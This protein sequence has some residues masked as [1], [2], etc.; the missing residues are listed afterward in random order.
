MKKLFLNMLLILALLIPTL[1]IATTL[2][3]TQEDTVE[4]VTS[5][6]FLTLA[7]EYAKFTFLAMLIL[8]ANHIVAGTFNF[9]L[10]LQDSLIPA[11]LAYGGGLAVAALDIYATSWDFFVEAVLGAP[12]DY[13]D[14][15]NLA[16]TGMIL[17]AFIK[18]LF[19]INQTQEKVALKKAN[20]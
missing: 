7:L 11:A 14:F 10:W 17:V 16:V 5:V 19:K 1:A 20:Q 4:T 8:A 12:T 15:T 3:L 6:N 18:G 2:S 13:T 9:K